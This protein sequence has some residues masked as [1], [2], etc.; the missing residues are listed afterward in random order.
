MKN[1]IKCPVYTCAGEIPGET[2]I[3]QGGTIFS[4]GD[5]NKKIGQ[6]SVNFKKKGIKKG[7]IVAIVSRNN[8]EYIAVLFALFRTGAIALPLNPKFPH[9]YIMEILNKTGAGFLLYSGDVNLSGSMKI[10]AFPFEDVTDHSETKPVDT[11]VDMGIKDDSTIILTSGSVG[12]PKGALHTFGNHY[13]S[14]LGSNENIL[15][16]KGDKWLLTL[17]LYHIGGMAV[18]FRSFLSGSTV[19]IHDHA[20]DTGEEI[21]KYG[22]T[23]ASVVPLQ[24]RKIT[25]YF[26]KKDIS[27]CGSLKAVLTG[28]SYVSESLIKEALKFNIPVYTT[29][30]LTEMSSQVTTIPEP[31]RSHPEVNQ[32]KLLRYRELKIEKDGEI[33]VRGKTLFKGYIEGGGKIIKELKNGWFPTGDM[34]GLKPD[35]SLLITGRKDNMFI[36]GGENIYP[37][38]IERELLNIPGLE[39]AI[40]VCIKDKKYEERPVAFINM[41]AGGDKTKEEIVKLLRSKLPPY[42]VPDRF[43]K[44]PSE[45][46]ESLKTSR[47]FFKKLFYEK[48]MPGEIL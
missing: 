29:Y 42:K 38:E 23:H 36:S 5:L 7:N 45:P 27:G 35:G 6:V 22:I 1:T 2:A 34:G 41:K 24:L 3:I 14:A 28:G 33:M 9:N 46:G 4:Y 40:V 48:N 13:F 15:L 32:G 21:A 20:E 25:D 39:E 18:L 8:L 17:P 30:G 10:P 47:S 12:G 26:E 44:W 31:V 11:G 19:V 43:F 16:N 37:E